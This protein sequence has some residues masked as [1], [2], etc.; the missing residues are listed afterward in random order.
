MFPTD[1]RP[2]GG[3]VLTGDLRVVKNDKLCQL[4]ECGPNFRDK[5]SESN[6]LTAVT[7]GLNDFV[8]R[9]VGPTLRASD[10]GPWKTE[11]LRRCSERIRNESQPALPMLDAEAREALRK[12]HRHLVFVATDKAANN[13]A[14][15]LRIYTATPCGPSLRPIATHTNYSRRNHCGSRAIS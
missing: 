13:F 2:Q 12:L 5:I 3:C 4:L 7:E 6:A 15:V 1:F 8:D 10:F 11:V 9:F 14:V